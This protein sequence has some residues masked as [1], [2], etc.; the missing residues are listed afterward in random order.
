MAFIT[1]ETRSDLIELSVAMLKQAP[2][3]ALLEELIALSVGGGSLADA[4]DHI[5]KTDAFK[6]EY[7]SFQTAE[8][9]AAEIFDNITTGGTVTADIRTAVIELAT[10]MLTSGSVTKAGLALAIAE[11]LAAPAAL[12]NTDFADIAQSFQNRADAAEYFVVTKELGGSTDAELAAAIASVTSDAATLTAANTAADATA[13]AEAVVAGQTFTLTTGLDTGSSFTGAS[14]DDTFTAQETGT[15]T[16]DTLTTGDNLKGGAGTDTLSIAVSGT[17]VGG[18]TSGVV[19]SSIEAISVFNNSTAA[20]EVDAA[21]MPGVTN[22]YVNGGANATT[23]DDLDTLANLH[24]ISTNVAA[25]VSTTA[26]AVAGTADEA[27]ILSNGAAQA[28]A[29]TATYDGLEVINFNAAGTTGS[30][31]HH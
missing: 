23:F 27:I 21:L 14:T 22:V 25:T 12:L 13:S 4:A 11:Y 5:A 28:A 18:Q 31:S 9:Y 15:A 1:A 19:T 16:T 7:P 17:I 10:G 8:Q 29:M 2:S 30:A 24:L 6:A 26:L 3:A 20:Y